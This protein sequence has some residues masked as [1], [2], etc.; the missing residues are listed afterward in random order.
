MRKLLSLSAGIVALMLSSAVDAHTL[1]VQCKKTTSADIVCRGLFTDGEVARAMTIQL[2]DEETEKVI[3]TG[4]TDAEGKYAFKAPGAVYSVVI[5][6]SKAEVASL[7][8]E[9]IW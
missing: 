3:A 1:Q 5:Q 7:S 9:D 6:A 2:I 8:S 4:K